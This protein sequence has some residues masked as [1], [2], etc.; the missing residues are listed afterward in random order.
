VNRRRLPSSRRGWIQ[1]TA[2]A[3]ALSLV[4]T[5]VAL[6]AFPGGGGGRPA[7]LAPGSSGSVHHYAWWDPR[8]WFGGGGGRAPQARTIAADGGPQTGRRLHEAAAP[9]PH[10]VSEIVSKRSANTRVYRLSNGRTQADISAGPVNYRDKRG[11]WRPIDT[12]VHRVSMPGYRYD[13]TA[14]T[15]RSYFGSSAARPVRFVA[16]GAGSLSMAL[17][18]AHASA[19]HVTKNTVSYP[20]VAAGASLGYQV[21]PSALKESIT[22]ASASAPA[23]YSYTVKVAGGLV[24]WQRR[25]GQIVLSRDGVGGPP[26][27]IIPQPFMTSAKSDRWSPYGKVWS[28]RVW[29]RMAWEAATHTLR[30]TITADKGW[31]DAA[32]RA[33]PVVID[34]TIEVAPT[35]SQAQ[36]TMV[37]SD[38]PSSNYNSIWRLSVGT[39]ASAD[40]RSLLSFPLSSIPS[41]TQIDSADLR[42]YYDQN[43]GTSSSNETIQADQATGAWNAS[44]A[45]WSNTS[46]LDG[47]EGLN[48]IV[49]DDNDPT[50]TSASG[51]W[52][53]ASASAATNG[54]YRYDQDATAGDKFTWVPQLTESG[55]W[56][57]ADHYVATS[58]AATNAPFTVT[59]NG[60]S[61]A[62]TVNQQS[63]TGGQWAVLDQ[64]PF[65]AGTAGKVVLGDGPAS[66]STRV[67]ADATRFRLWGTQVV[68]PNVANVWDSFPVRNIVQSW[69]NGSANYGFVVK[70]NSES[71]FGLGGPR[72]EAS[73]YYYQ[74]EVA[75]YPQLVVTYGRPSVTLNQI[76]TIHAT[77]ADLSWTPYQDPTPGTNP[78]DDLAEYQVHRSVY[79]SFSPDASTLVSPVAAGTTSYSDSSEPPTPASSSDP[80]GN[81][82]YYMVAVKTADGQ[83]VPG[84][85]ELVRLPKAGYTIQIINASGATTLSKAQPTTNEQ[86]LTGQPWL[87][88][89]DDS[90]TF[91]VTRTVVNYPS[92]SAAG[93]PSGATVTDAE[94]K[95]WGWYNDTNGSASFDAHALTQSF[96][97]ATATWNNASSGTPWTTA[98][99]AYSST[100]TGTVSGL[101][102]DPNRQEWPVTSTVQ[103]WVNTPSSEH[104]LLVR[105]SSET[106]PA[107]QELFL[108]TSAAE[109]ALRPELVVIY[110]DTV[111]E[112][113]YYVPG[114][115]P[116]LTSATSYSV[117]VTVTN[118]TGTTLSSSNW[119]LSYHWTLPDGTDVSNSGNQV[120]TS[121]PSS[122]AAGDTVTV[123]AN[124]TTPDT[125]ATGNERTAYSLGWDLYN[126]STGTWLSGTNSGVPSITP[127]NQPASVAQP[128]S[129]QL[130]L[131]KYYQYT[132]VNT[133]SGSALLNN[134]ANGNVVWSYNPFSNPSRGFATFVRISYNSMDTSD[135][136]MGFGWSLQASSLM[137]LGTPLDFHPNPNPTTVTLTDGDGTSHWFTWDSAANQWDSPPGLHYFLQQVGTCDPSGK[138]Q[139]ARAWLLTRPDRTQFYFDCQ[140]F[141][142]AVIDHNGNEADFTYT[143]KI[144]NNKPVKFLDYITDPSGRQTL[145]LTYFHKGDSYSYIDSNGNVASSTNLTNPKIIDQVK[146]ITDV[147]GRTITFL[148]TTQGLMAQ[149][150]DGDGSSTPKVFKFGYD[151]TQGNKNVKLVSVTD[152]RG[153][154]NPAGHTT[155]L[156]YYTAPQDPKFKWS[157]E[158]ITD[159]LGG[160][161]GFAYTEP[162]PGQPTGSI[163]T[164]VTDQNGHT[165]TYALD[166]SGR[167]TQVKNALTQTT[168]LAWDNDNNVIQLIEDNGATTTWTYD[169]KTGYPLSTK[170]AEANK[171][172]TAGTT[173]TYQTGLSGHIA[174]LISK[175]TPQQRLWTFGYDANGNLTSVTDPDGNAPGAAAGSYTTKY[176]YDS[177]GNLATATDANGNPTTYSNYD[178]T[179]Y[180]QTITDALGNAWTYGYDSRGNVTSVS[181]PFN[182]TTT[183]SYDVFGRPGQIVS[184]K[185][186]N[187]SPPVYITTPAPE[188]DGNDN[189]VKSF[190]A[191]NAETA[192]TYN[193]NDELTVK[194]A[195]PDSSGTYQPETTYGYDPAGNQTSVTEPNGNV[196]GAAPG[197][198]T[199]TYGYDAINE[200]TSVTD[201]A[202]DKTTYGYDDVGNR[203]S[204]TDPLGNI[205][206]QDYNLN[207][208]P[209]VATDAGGYTTSKS[210]DLD[211]KVTAT[212]DQAGDTTQYT[213]DP[214]G[215]LVQV[216]APHDT[217]GGTT[218]F[219]TTQYVYDQVGNRTEVLTPR[220]V[221]AG[222]SRTSAC[223]ASLT[224]PFTYVTQ[225]DADNHIAAQRSA[226]D[227]ADSTYNTPAV[228]TYSYN[229]AG[230]LKTVTA[231]SSGMP[232]QGGPNVTKY[233]YFDNNWIK[234]ST[235]PW[236]IATSY[237]YNNDG[238]QASRTL[239]SDDGAMSRTMSWS[240]YPNDQLSALDDHGVPTGLAS[241]AVDNSDTQNITST[242]TWTKS[243]SGSG[244]QGYDYV[245]GT[246]TGTF[247]WTLNIPTDG[248]YTVYVKYPVISGASTSAAYKVNYNGGSATVNVNQTANTGQNGWVK[249]GK[250]AFTQAGTGQKVTLTQ[251]STAKVVADAVSVVR[252][253]TGV[254]DTSHH[255]FAYTYDATGNLQGIADNSLTSPTV[256]NY[257]MTY[258]QVNR[259]TEVKET[260]SV[261]NT[262][263]DTTYGYDADSDLATR[264]H[265]SAS[266]AY[267]Y[268]AR[269]LLTQEIDTPAS[270]SAQ[271]T[272]FTYNSRGLRS[273]E[274]KPNSNNVTYSYF[275]DGLLKHQLET[276]TAGATVAEHTYTYNP[277]GVKASD[278]ETLM[279]ADTSASMTHS[280][281]YVYDPRD[282]IEKVITDGSATETYTHDATDNV[283]SQTVN[284]T[285]TTFNYD[286]DRLLSA[287]SGGSTVNY[288]Y[289]SL[290]RLD[291]VTGGSSPCGVVERNTYDGFDNIASHQQA[292]AAGTGCDTTSYTYDPLNRQASQK[293]N[294]GSTTQY[295]YLGLSSELISE[296]GGSVPKS[297]TY[298][299]SGERLSQTSTQS[300]T[301]STDYYSYNDH[302]DVEALTNS[303]NGDTKSTY[304][305]SAYGQPIASQWTGQDKNNTKPDATKTPFNSYR[306]N[307]MR[308]DSSS[309]QY[310]MGFRN[311]AAN[312]NQF[313][314]RDMYNGALAD[315]SLTTDPFTG[316]RYTFGAGNP[317]SNIEL[318]GHMFPAGGGAAGC[319][320]GTIGCRGYNPRDTIQN[321]ESGGVISGALHFL[322]SLI[323]AP[324]DILHAQN[325]AIPTLY[326]VN[327]GGAFDRWWQHTFGISPSSPNGQAMRFTSDIAQ[328]A[329]FLA[330]VGAAADA[331]RGGDLAAAKAA[332]ASASA[333]DAAVGAPRV[334][335]VGDLKLPGVPQGA[336]GVPTQTGRG[337]TYTIPSGTPELDPRVAQIR[338]MDPVTAGKY[339][340]PNGYAVY[341]NNIG[342]TVNPLTGRVISNSDPFAHIG[343]P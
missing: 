96:D 193:G 231:P 212:T 24:P 97:P 42:M 21:T 277:D 87:A 172:G 88:V 94:L 82:F 70:S 325:T 80:Y 148:Y 223:V 276:N 245:T 252:D 203:I 332:A 136:S 78:G 7:S 313:L 64:K 236:G 152:P 18:G 294:S 215:D 191:T 112:D 162:A 117:P 264:G 167:P 15:F 95:M 207:H 119:V 267:T 288:N 308:W 250:Y 47:T 256:T 262:V 188:Y 113:T 38:T 77:G 128:G 263:H 300:G 324:A 154:T 265:D 40:V 13:N 274:G 185:D 311:Y 186:H 73:G 269:N 333:E 99:G 279:N 39:T 144:S 3:A 321:A 72:Y 62:Y 323:N 171:N 81:A 282:R 35:P 28:A 137:R 31:L 2:V 334:I 149:M 169:P 55:N 306:F 337:L 192:Y 278:A 247:T 204:V 200:Q 106:S 235:D 125:S 194:Q 133:G 140:G 251:N 44:T 303:T 331:L 208:W 184:P 310:D 8:G 174:D 142:T 190:T 218:T 238:Q 4:L 266:S 234:S 322:D 315:M 237:D 150:T 79:E 155:N 292:N 295:S 314:S 240:Y 49:V 242:G 293:V 132:G 309:G 93:I 253:N 178:V 58:N 320:Y 243:T 75:T 29:Q 326:H 110:L 219:N 134:A 285:P 187:A 182:D 6:A 273:T 54:E 210:Y 160:T 135:S 328:G 305:Y 175:L 100:V 214:R 312:L 239:T 255:T 109:P 85:T 244:Y 291:T 138:T 254:S 249:L 228:T 76:T 220:A 102:N 90:S 115:P 233:S 107:E 63:G 318:D 104:G 287:T 69:L 163:Q 161:T 65:V 74:G 275:A 48:E 25:N 307:A 179:G 61:Q 327:L 341:M 339:Q 153:V 302:S 246:G 221:A 50:G 177:V 227:P 165:S 10:R 146:S 124:L 217:S 84:P 127:L 213:L 173:Y 98:G 12:T 30:L 86:H 272:T 224:C 16:P 176:S 33:F 284:N 147:S 299:P 151:M 59:Y 336:T 298:T 122:L 143:S 105:E 329:L 226:Y 268:N 241:Q 52:P 83:V 130:G 116:H 280:L 37:E 131:E 319:P 211:G 296:T 164:V 168:Q 199:T 260:G 141:Q 183:Y 229:A 57:V 20:G 5:G 103:G 317:V 108:D 126:K 9:A 129:D 198:Y 189:V 123:N 158:T 338:I 304:G 205:T 232:A 301:T 26:A 197:S 222:T 22:L 11:G 111:P 23:S 196:S 259:V 14:N 216:M 290:G 156:A 180:P 261:G 19:P 286:R 101:T 17:D 91:G 89:G 340:Y 68:N 56:W 1:L 166:S 34:P 206:K 145:T 53:T 114:L 157:T 71:T 67:I 271:T 342:Q 181:D 343:L 270:G 45:T 248:N 202:G 258:D 257:T 330:P 195:P 118:T 297:Y 51:A 170:D 32:G 60:G 159:R 121:L 283:T 27:L 139:N 46:A 230:R 335:R 209:T 225:Y 43:F 36:N 201:A 92:M 289:D 281:S 66:T 41:G 316:N 120:Q